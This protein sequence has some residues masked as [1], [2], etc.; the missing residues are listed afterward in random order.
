[1][2]AAPW[3]VQPGRP[4]V[5]ASTRIDKETDEH[6]CHPPYVHSEKNDGNSGG[7]NDEPEEAL[8][9]VDA[10]LGG[11]LRDVIAV[12]RGGEVHSHHDAE[13]LEHRLAH[14][15]AGARK[16]GTGDH[17][18]GHELGHAVL[19]RATELTAPAI[20]PGV[21]REVAEESVGA[22]PDC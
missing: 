6:I 3:T 11:G 19:G 7:L 9:G 22:H 5:L 18:R 12:D 16:G 20:H 15:R 10:H 4:A 21:R 2:T 8:V 17:G 1:M 13:A 14:E